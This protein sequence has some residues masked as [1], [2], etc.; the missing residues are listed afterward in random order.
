[1]SAD[2]QTGLPSLNTEQLRF[3]HVGDFRG[4][5]REQEKVAEFDRWLA[6]IKADAFAQGRDSQRDHA[7]HMERER[8]IKLLEGAEREANTAK[9]IT[10]GSYGYWEGLN[11]AIALIKGENIE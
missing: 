3:L 1:M 8:I 5:K 2:P 6:E 4:T 11:K 7:E 9:P 10:G